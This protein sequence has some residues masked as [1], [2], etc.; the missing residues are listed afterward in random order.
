MEGLLDKT[1]A[2]SSRS[3]DSGVSSVIPTIFGPVEGV[4]GA[5]GLNTPMR[6]LSF[7]VAVGTALEFYIK[8]GYAFDS[9]GN[10]KPPVFLD[11]S[12]GATYTPP[13]LFPLIAGTICALY[14]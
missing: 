12:P 7:V 3:A 14:I 10:P 1:L 11:N 9:K 5:I 2:S 8:P 6:R 4:L 13:G